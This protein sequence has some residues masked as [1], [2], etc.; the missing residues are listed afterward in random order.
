MCSCVLVPEF[1]LYKAIS[2][3]LQGR[4]LSK[5]LKHS[6]GYQEWTLSQT[7]FALSGGYQTYKSTGEHQIL[8]VDH[9]GVD[10]K[11]LGIFLEFIMDDN[12]H[13]KVPTISDDELNSRSKSDWVI[14]LIALLQILWFLVQILFRAIQHYHITALEV[15]TVAFVFCSVFIYGLL[16]DQ[17]Q[18]VE[19]PV[20]LGSPTTPRTRD[21]VAEGGTDQI[22]DAGSR[23]E[24]IGEAAVAARKVDELIVGRSINYWSLVDRVTVLVFLV[25]SCVFG[26]IHC[27][28]WNSPFPTFKERLAWWVPSSIALCRSTF[29]NCSTWMRIHFG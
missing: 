6:E 21:V 28:A 3:F 22:D 18:N 11:K 17:P 19:Y 23:L 8:N 13:Y 14:K 7:L 4:T 1:F 15:L 25:C 29:N 12:G 27:L 20:L 2:K 24:R 9:G 26:A 5:F 16:W 10:G